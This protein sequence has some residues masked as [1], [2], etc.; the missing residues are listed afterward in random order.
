MCTIEKIIKLKIRIDIFKSWTYQKIL[1]SL[2]I[3]SFFVC[4][5]AHHTCSWEKSKNSNF[6]RGLV[7]E[8]SQRRDVDSLCF[9]CKAESDPDAE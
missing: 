1:K 5:L 2:L 7:R 4:N 9:I 6:T 8:V 3:E